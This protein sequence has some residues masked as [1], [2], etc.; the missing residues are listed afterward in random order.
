MVVFSAGTYC[1]EVV[2]VQVADAVQGEAGRHIA[3][4]RLDDFD[5]RPGLSRKADRRVP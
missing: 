4:H 1:V 2:R 5:L 3:Q